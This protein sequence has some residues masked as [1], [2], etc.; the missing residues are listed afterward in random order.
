[1]VWYSPF[2]LPPEVLTHLRQTVEH[3]VQFGLVQG[4]AAARDQEAGLPGGFAPL[5]Y[6]NLPACP[7]AVRYR[8][9]QHRSP[10]PIPA[11]A[12]EVHVGAVL[13]DRGRRVVLHCAHRLVPSTARYRGR[14]HPPYGTD[15]A[16][17]NR[18]R[19][20][21]RRV[22]TDARASGDGSGQQRVV[23]VTACDCASSI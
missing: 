7:V 3:T 18:Q 14:V 20:R 19:V 4:D 11:E 15:R 6:V 1:A 10:R 13:L 16:R 9:A 12:V 5:P 2:P 21:E 17:R 23:S 8:H 22:L